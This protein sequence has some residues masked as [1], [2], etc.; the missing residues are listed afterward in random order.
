MVT[1]RM[2]PLEVAGR[3]THQVGIPIHWSYAGETVGGCANE[4]AA[5]VTDINVSM[6][7]A[8]A[9]ACQ[10]RAGRLEGVRRPTAVAAARVL[11]EAPIP[12]TPIEAQPEGRQFK[13]K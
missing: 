7:E 11:D 8:K 2:R 5:L 4:L 3:I 1:R 13:P 12:D 10:I 9:F 6:H